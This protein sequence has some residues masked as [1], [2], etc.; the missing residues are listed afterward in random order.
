MEV[1]Q[2]PP[3][4]GSLLAHF[5]VQINDQI[6]LKHLHLSLNTAGEFRVFPPNLRGSG[7][8]WFGPELVRELTIEAC[9]EY[10]ALTGGRLPRYDLH[11][12]A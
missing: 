10:G 9:A 1:V 12:A 7:S 6:A 11:T 2:R 4:G 3:G 5:D 8:A